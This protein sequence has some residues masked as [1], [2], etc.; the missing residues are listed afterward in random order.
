MF[1]R[2]GVRGFTLIELLM[3]VALVAVLASIA[4]PSYL[5]YL[6]K[7]NRADVQQLMYQEAV[8]LE[9]IYSR[10][11][12][13]PDRSKFTIN[14][15]HSHYDLRYTPLGK[16]AGAVGTHRNLRF[17]I[18]AT[19]KTNTTQV[20]DICGTLRLDEQGKGFSDGPVDVCW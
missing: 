16:P 15:V 14:K 19:P 5:D 10:N 6:R 2:R 3:V 1:N 20:S 8:K 4:L 12:G 17:S 11:G 7:G 13:Y 18:S 9:R